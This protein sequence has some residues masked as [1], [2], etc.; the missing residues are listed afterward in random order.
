MIAIIHREFC[1]LLLKLCKQFRR[2]LYGNQTVQVIISS[3]EAL[4]SQRDVVAGIFGSHPAKENRVCNC[5][6]AVT[7][8]VSSDDRLFC[9]GG[10]FFSP[11]ILIYPL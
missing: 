3:Y 5:D 1:C 4:L 8:Y 11:F 2:I 9:R 7:V 6:S 10:R